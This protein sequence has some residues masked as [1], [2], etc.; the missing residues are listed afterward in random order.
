MHNMHYYYFMHGGLGL[1]DFLIS[2]EI[3][4]EAVAIAWLGIAKSKILTVFL[5]L[6]IK[7]KTLQIVPQCGI[8]RGCATI[9]F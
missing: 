9:L 8:I 4:T 1:C 7:D 2:L 3:Y 5:G 6:K